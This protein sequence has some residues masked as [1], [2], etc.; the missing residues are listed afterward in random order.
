MTREEKAQVIAGLTEKFQES[1]HYYITDTSGLSVAEI[2]KFRAMC[3]KQGI[4]YKVAKNTLIKKALESLEWGSPKLDE[5][6]KGVSG[7][8]FVKEN[9]S[10]PAK[11]IKDYKKA[12]PKDRPR[13]KAASIDSDIFVGEEQL[14]FLSK[15]K[16]KNELIGE[17]INLLQSPAKEVLSLLQSGEHKLA[18]IVKTL[19]ERE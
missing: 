15:L 9:A 10:A 16:T 17:V 8:M 4:E 5:A 6:L 11:L 3:F 1:D 7:I 13:F 12:D 2:N 19:S 18:G 14:E